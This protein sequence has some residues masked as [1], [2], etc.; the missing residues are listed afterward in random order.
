EIILENGGILLRNHREGRVAVE[1]LHGV[2]EFNEGQVVAFIGRHFFV[3]ESEISLSSLPAP[4]AGLLEMA[5]FL[6]ATGERLKDAYSVQRRSG[7]GEFRVMLE[8]RA[9]GLLEIGEVEEH[10]ALVVPLDED[11]DLVC[12]AVQRPAALVAREV[13]RAIDVFR[14]SEFHPLST[15]GTTAIKVGLGASERR[16]GEEVERV[17]STLQ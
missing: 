13:M 1:I 3:F 7:F 8:D 4:C 2:P 11:V 9:Q 14:D 17:F 16:H 10:A 5:E 12:V 15:K 6:R